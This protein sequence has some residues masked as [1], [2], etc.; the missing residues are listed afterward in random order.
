MNSI[1]YNKREVGQVGIPYLPSFKCDVF[2]WGT[3]AAGALSLAGQLATNRSNEKMTRETNEQNYKIHQEQMAAARKQFEDEVAE[4]RYLIADDRDYNSMVNQVARMREAGINPALA[5]YGGAGGN[6]ASQNSGSPS[7]D[8]PSAPQMVAPQNAPL[9]FD[10]LGAGIN[11]AY[12][13]YLDNKKANADIQA[14]NAEAFSA[15]VTALDNAKGLS[16]EVKNSLV[17]EYYKH[18]DMFKHDTSGQSWR[19]NDQIF[20]GLVKDNTLKQFNINMAQD[21]SDEQ[22]KEWQ[23]NATRFDNEIKEFNAR[24]QQYADEHKLNEANLDMIERLYNQLKSEDERWKKLDDYLHGHGFL[25]MFFNS[26]LNTFNNLAP[27]FISRR[28]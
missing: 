18:S 17:E 6:V 9:P 19:T 26:A 14:R 5:M 7:G 12:A 22:R 27:F 10:Q 16:M 1:R 11:S 4:N 25:R 21:M 23:R 20:E 3:A 15:F 24:M 8:I 13:L 2:G 28:K